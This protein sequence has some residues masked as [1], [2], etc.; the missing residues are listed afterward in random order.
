MRSRL[1]LALVPLVA[2][3]VALTTDPRALIYGPDGVAVRTLPCPAAVSAARAWAPASPAGTEIDPSAI[4]I[5]TWNI[6]KQDDA[7][8]QADLTRFAEANDILL[9]QEVTLDDTLRGILGSAGMR[10][11]MASSFLYYDTDIGVLTATR[12]VPVAHCTLRVVEPLIQ[13]PKSSVITWL[14]VKGSARTLAVANIHSINFSLSLDTYEAQ[15]AAVGDALADH[16]GPIVFAG[17]LNTWTGARLDALHKVAARLRLAEIPFAEGRS[18][19]FGKEVDHILVRGLAVASAAAIA[20]KSSDH[21]PATAVL[22]LS[23][24]QR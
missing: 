18:R 19:F 4:R 17:D 13:L 12:A 6:H 14:P 20:V 7:G 22:R 21:N 24:E 23:P 3:C 8:W 2:G 15:L 1:A 16:E 9:L 5:A 11:V 10:W